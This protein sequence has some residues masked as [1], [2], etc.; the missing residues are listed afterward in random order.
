MTGLV[1]TYP[2]PAAAADCPSAVT[3]AAQKAH[4]GAT[5]SSCK[6]ETEHGKAQYEVKLTGAGGQKIEIDV[7]PE[8]A[9]LQTEEYIAVSDLP[10]AVMAAFVSKY[11]GA[12]PSRAEKQTAADGTISYELAFTSGGK[13]RE[14]TFKADGN[15]VE[16]E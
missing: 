16:E 10:P 13:K 3:T 5:V 7:D 12:T 8:G 15:L 14:S 9:I 1:L 11:K 4:P 6:K 2:F